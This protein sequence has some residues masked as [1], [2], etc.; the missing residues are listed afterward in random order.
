MGD[1]SFQTG[2]W[3]VRHR[4]LRERLVG[5]SEWVEFAGTCR[6]FE[7]MGGEANVEDNII[8]DPAG[9]YRAAAFRRRHPETGLWSIWWHDGR[10]GA[11]DPPVVG[12]FADG[13][14]TFLAKDT[15]N[16]RPILVR[17]VWSEISRS[18]ARWD[19]A[20]SIDDGVNWE[21]NWAMR[22]ERTT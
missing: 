8:D 1:F 20:F 21:V 10:M 19:Q 16:G 15:L 2:E 14:G 22:F 5:S 12:R 11:Q 18:A 4:K 9:A 7:V 13:G 3:R 17:F 6:A